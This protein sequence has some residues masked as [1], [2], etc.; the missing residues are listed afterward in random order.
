VEGAR[1]EH[2]GG[3]DELVEPDIEGLGAREHRAAGARVVAAGEQH[4]TGTEQRH[5][6]VVGALGLHEDD[7]L[8]EGAT[9][10]ARHEDV[11]RLVVEADAV[12][13]ACDEHTR[14]VEARGR[15]VG[16]R[17]RHAADGGEGARA[18][19]VDLGR[20][21]GAAERADA[22]RHEHAPRT[23]EQLG[24][25]TDARRRHVD[26]RSEAAALPDLAGAHG[27]R[28][29]T[30]DEHA[31]RRAAEQRRRVIDAAAAERARRREGLRGVR[32]ELGRGAHGAASCGSTADEQHLIGRDQGRRVATAC[33]TE[34]AHECEGARRSA[35]LGRAVDL[36][37]GDPRAGRVEAASDEDLLLRQGEHGRGV[38]RAR[39]VE[40]A[41]GDPGGI[42]EQGVREP[43]GPAHDELTGDRVELDALAA[44]RGRRITI[45]R[46]A[47]DLE[48]GFVTHAVRV[49]HPRARD[50]QT[51]HACV[52]EQLEH[53]VREAQ[54]THR[55]G[56]EAP[57]QLALR[58]RCREQHELLDPVWIDAMHS[59]GAGQHPVVE[60]EAVFDDG[61]HVGRRA[62][63]REAHAD[64]AQT[65]HEPGLAIAAQRDL[66]HDAGR[67]AEVGEQ[68]RAR[69]VPGRRAIDRERTALRWVEPSEPGVT[70]CLSRICVDEVGL[71]EARTA[72]TWLG[73]ARGERRHGGTE[74]ERQESAKRPAHERESGAHRARR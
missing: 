1:F 48:L 61:L 66:A 2:V 16:A 56:R 21:H 37:V 62:F 31:R 3:Q 58:A 18:G 64:A 25:V 53:A 33:G 20:L 36:G 28:V 50:A 49:D 32:V 54:R 10:R 72:C 19:V 38:V 13:A 15:R 55:L 70:R 6:G 57:A 43:L 63:E 11:G 30:G 68:A 5:G 4:A 17:A 40:R 9:G 35:G 52:I 39:H 23:R 42:D 29:A 73:A 59:H 74:P 7:L 8:L 26:R 24:R 47:V 60:H 45:D 22:A 65:L 41:G 27:A 14:V 46:A 34:R 67:L 12:G 44:P 69:S 51:R 71:G